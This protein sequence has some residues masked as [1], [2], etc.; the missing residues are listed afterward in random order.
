[1]II[2]C[3]NCGFRYELHRKP[4]V[5]FHCRKCNFT[6]PFQVVL[7]EQS[8]TVNMNVT[9][10]ESN[11]TN[12]SSVP[13]FYQKS[14]SGNETQV[15]SNLDGGHT[16]VVPELAGDK[17]R[18]IPS[19][20]STHP[21]RPKQ[22]KKGVLVVSF[23]GRQYS[24]IPLPFG[25]FDLGRL[26]SDSNAKI[27]IAPDMSMSRIH[28]GMRTIKINGQIV[29]QITSV[30]NE[31]PVYVNNQPIDKGK[32]CTLKNGDQIRM[33]DTVILFRLM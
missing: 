24:T 33:G 12:E 15:V 4:P 19:L 31:N 28:A 14:G 10:S 17:T 23:N 21:T 27:K 3:P 8:E 5:T 1:M 30:K 29:Y 9:N 26:S 6:I 13:S 2:K 20:Q 22:P 7:N 32:A 18:V 25:S 11:I 16:R